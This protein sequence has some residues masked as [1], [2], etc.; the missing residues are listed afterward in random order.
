MYGII[1]CGE[2]LYLLWKKTFITITLLNES[3]THAMSIIELFTFSLVKKNAQFVA[4]H[5]VGYQNMKFLA[6]TATFFNSNLQVPFYCTG[7]S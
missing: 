2:Y 3:I 4:V 6:F 5:I 1:I 7:I